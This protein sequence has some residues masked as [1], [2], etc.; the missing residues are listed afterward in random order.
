MIPEGVKQLVR[1][2]TAALKEGDET[3]A[4]ALTAELRE[5]YPLYFQEI[6]KVL[7]A[8]DRGGEKHE[9]AVKRR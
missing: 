6:R 3:R 2:I 8:L 1:D 5:Q 4:Y 9:T 7:A